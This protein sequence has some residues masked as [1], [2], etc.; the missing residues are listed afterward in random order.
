MSRLP[1]AEDVDVNDVSDD[2][3][4]PSNDDSPTPPHHGRLESL[5]T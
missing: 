4:D 1:Q 2:D 3:S 5:K